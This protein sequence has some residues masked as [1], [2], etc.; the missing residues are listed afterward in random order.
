MP[1]SKS[2]VFFLS[3][4]EVKLRGLVGDDVRIAREAAAES[5]ILY[6]DWP[7]ITHVQGEW[8]TKKKNVGDRV[9][10]YN[11]AGL[12]LIYVSFIC[13]NQIFYTQRSM[14]LK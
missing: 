9:E 11:L 13:I 7:A 6:L 3:V 8:I 4:K 1:V 5:N 10:K 2:A 14:A 12:A